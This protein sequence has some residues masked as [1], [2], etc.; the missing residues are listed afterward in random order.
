MKI[1][2]VLRIVSINSLILL[3]FS[4]TFLVATAQENPEV[5]GE[6]LS[7]QT[8]STVPGRDPV[9]LPITPES[10]QNLRTSKAGALDE[11]HQNRILNLSA[12][13]SNRMEAAIARLFTIA[14]RLSSRIEKTTS[15]G[16]DTIAAA[17]KLNEANTLLTQARINLANIDTLVYNA[18]TSPEPRVSWEK[19]RTVY[20]ETA[21]LIRRAHQTI[22]ETIALLKT[23]ETTPNLNQSTTTEPA[24]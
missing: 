1:F 16:I 4:A 7:N 15:L 24:L 14:T 11:I 6:E 19:V 20:V 18:T 12:N 10:Q 2:T 3:A 5:Q 21:G 22:R 23:A 8:T 13:I 17:N 9:V